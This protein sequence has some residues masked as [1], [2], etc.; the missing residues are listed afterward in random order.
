[1]IAV[2]R[3]T[4]GAVYH[5]YD[6]PVTIVFEFLPVPRLATREQPWVGHMAIKAANVPQ[7]MKEGLFMGQEDVIPEEGYMSATEGL[8]HDWV[9]EKWP[10][11][12]HFFLRDTRHTPPRWMAHAQCL[13]ADVKPLGGIK[14]GDLRHYHILFCLSAVARGQIIYKFDRKEPRDFFC[15]YDDMPLEGL[16]PHPKR[17]EGRPE[18]VFTDLNSPD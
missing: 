16:W 12:R 5:N 13:A 14:L 6:A 8:F 4:A 2:P 11:N 3:A 15:I 7:L 18:T 9:K 10:H 17:P 1:M